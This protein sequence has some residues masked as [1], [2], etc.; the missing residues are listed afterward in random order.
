MYAI[1]D[2]KKQNV[3]DPLISKR[4]QYL[5][6]TQ[7][8]RAVLK[9]GT[10]MLVRR[11]PKADM[12]HL[13]SRRRD[14][15][16]GARCR[17][18]QPCKLD[19]TRYFPTSYQRRVAKLS[20]RISRQTRTVAIIDRLVPSESSGASVD[21]SQHEKVQWLAKWC[22][23]MNNNLADGTSSTTSFRPLGLVF[24]G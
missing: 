5:L 12:N 19:A 21:D 10:T 17:V 14:Y 20:P 13:L 2:M 1:T 3:Y 22:V 6:A 18:I 8:V 9:I 16:R 4:Q 23:P 11:R 24:V 15:G 7:L